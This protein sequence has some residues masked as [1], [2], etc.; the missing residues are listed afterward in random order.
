MNRYF[1][2]YFILKK[3]KEL[4]R[5][6]KKDIL[7]IKKDKKKFMKLVNCDLMLNSGC[8]LSLCLSLSGHQIREDGTGSSLRSRRSTRT[9]GRRA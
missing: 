9:R 1:N 3:F 2:C 5:G 4:G 8:S 6:A 7:L